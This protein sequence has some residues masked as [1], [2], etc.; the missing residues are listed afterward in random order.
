MQLQA[1]KA[2]HSLIRPRSCASLR[3][4]LLLAMMIACTFAVHASATTDN[5]EIGT[6]VEAIWRMQS[7][8]FYHHSARVAYSCRA[9]REKIASILESVGAHESAIVQ[10]KCTGNL[11]RV[12]QVRITVGSPVEAT[13]ENIQRATTFDARVELIAR[14]ANIHLPTAVD[15]ERFPAT[16]RRVSL[17][18]HGRSR[19]DASDCELVRQMIKQVLP[20]LSTRVQGRPLC[21]E[22]VTRGMPHEV[23]ALVRDSAV[24]SSSA[25]F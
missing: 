24:P 7:F 6:R 3:A 25:G 4:V 11:L 15:I 13:P 16:W 12:A 1:P 18:G 17:R 23:V 10:T 22:G 5:D 19:L 8:D 9:L 14:T 2:D 20:K 21:T